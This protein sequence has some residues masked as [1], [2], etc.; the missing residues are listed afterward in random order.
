MNLID[1]HIGENISKVKVLGRVDGYS[2]KNQKYNCVCDCGNNVTKQYSVLVHAIKYGHQVSCG[3]IVMGKWNKGNT[4]DE[5]SKSKIG[6]KHNRLSIVDIVKN[7]PYG[8]KMVCKCDCGGVTEQLYADIKKGK[9][10]SCG[11]YGKE[12]QSISGSVYGLKNGTTNCSKRKWG[13]EKDSEFIRMRSGF[14]VMY[15]MILNKENIEWE[16]EPKRFKLSDGLRYTPDFYLPKQDLWVD[17]KGRVTEKN[18][19]KHKLF[20]E[21]GYNLDLVFIK[22]IEKRLGLK[23]RKFLKEWKNEAKSDNVETPRMVAASTE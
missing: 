2:T 8:Y 5:Y 19:I 22:E 17:V 20:R 16:Y 9:V 21:L 11:C 3:C 1:K 7:K 18:R 23:Y 15:A 4:N 6:E 10:K 14:E 13:I 12:Q